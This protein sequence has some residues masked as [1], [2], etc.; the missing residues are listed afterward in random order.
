[1]QNPEIQNGSR[2]HMLLVEYAIQ[3]KI[4]KNSKNLKKCVNKHIQVFYISANY[5]DKMAYVVFYA[6]KTNHSPT[7]DF[8]ICFKSTNFFFAETT[9]NNT[10]ICMLAIYFRIFLKKIMILFEVLTRSRHMSSKAKTGFLEELLFI[11]HRITKIHN[12]LHPVSA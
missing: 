10:Y 7:W 11:T 4:V 1:M 6:E 5:C 9:T 3:K 8:K 12:S 2:A